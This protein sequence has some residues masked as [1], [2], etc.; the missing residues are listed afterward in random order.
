MKDIK[1][2]KKLYLLK[3]IIKD[4]VR[5]VV[6]DELRQIIR[7]ELKGNKPVI[8]ESYKQFLPKPNNIRQN[9]RPIEAPMSKI[10]SNPIENMLKL[11]AQSMTGDEY[12]SISMGAS[13]MMTTDNIPAA[14]FNPQMMESIGEIEEWSPSSNIRMPSM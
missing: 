10:I 8:N 5:E 3:E 13:N 4:A 1:G 14:N 9:P 7:E 12:R 2:N 11:T 6:Q